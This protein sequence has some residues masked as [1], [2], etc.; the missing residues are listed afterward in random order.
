ME[1]PV[2]D[3]SGPQK[4]LETTE[5]PSLSSQTSLPAGALE[6][7]LG[8]L[9]RWEAPGES[10]DRLPEAPGG[11]PGAVCRPKLQHSTALLS[12]SRQ[13]TVSQGLFLT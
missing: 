2:T 5:S 1:P 3:T 13:V 11:A 7:G 6:P 12:D 4:E 9:E 10:M 8:V